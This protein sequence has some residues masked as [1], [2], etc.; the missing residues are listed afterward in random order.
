MRASI[1]I[2]VAVAFAGGPLALDLCAASCDA[3]HAV[4][5]STSAPPCHH[6]SAAGPRI[7][8]TP[9]PCGHDHDATVTA[10]TADAAPAAKTLNTATTTGLAPVTVL[11]AVRLLFP[12][13][14]NPPGDPLSRDLS[15]SLRV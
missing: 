1:A 5:T 4:S 6:S 9:T 14:A 11:T 12:P 3:A 10:A 2:V 7:G 15:A 13:F 8:H